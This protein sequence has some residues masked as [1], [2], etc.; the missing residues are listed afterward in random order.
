MSIETLIQTEIDQSSSIQ[1]SI[2]MSKKEDTLS[3]AK[4]TEEFESETQEDM[5]SL[6]RLSEMEKSSTETLSQLHCQKLLRICRKNQ[7]IHSNSSNLSSKRRILLF[8]R[9]I[10]TLQIEKPPYK[11][12]LP[13]NIPISILEKLKIQQIM[14]NMRSEISKIDQE[15]REFDSKSAEI[16]VF[17]AE[18]RSE[19]EGL[20]VALM[21]TLQASNRRYI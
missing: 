14:H 13:A 15:I 4:Y 5:V 16:P 20:E 9:K 3:S 10:E 18:N 17:P 12:E 19:S 8:K 6:A 21:K 2:E 11:H 1:E 7:Q